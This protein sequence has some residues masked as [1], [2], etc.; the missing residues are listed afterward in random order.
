LSQDGLH[1]YVTESPG[2]LL[3]VPLSNLNRASATV[4]ASGLNGIDQIALDEAHGFAFVAEFTG[5]HIQRITL[6]GGAKTIV[7]N[8]FA[9]RGVLVTDDGRFLLVSSDADTITQFDL[10]TNTSKVL[11]SGL[12]APRH[13]TWSDAGQSLVLFPVRNPSGVVMKLDLTTTPPTTAAITGATQHDPYSVAVLSANQL[14]IVTAQTVEEVD[15]TASVF[16][17]GGPILLGIGFVPA[18]TVHLPNGYADTTM[19]PTYFFQVKDS[20]FGG[21]LPL[22]INWQH[23]DS[24]G[25][26]LYK[27]FVNNVLIK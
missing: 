14:L 26:T 20:P 23:A 13:L 4:V 11:A 12:G 22:Q 6:A 25:A 17:P 21:T 9:P 16:L 7:A 10:V 19:D 3:R 2:T 27:V 5:G 24:M 18:D 1:A 15:L 8:V